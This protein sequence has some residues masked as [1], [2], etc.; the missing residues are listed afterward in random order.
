MSLILKYF[1]VVTY[2]FGL[3]LFEPQSVYASTSITV[4]TPADQ[5]KISILGGCQF[6]SSLWHCFQ[7]SA[8]ARAQSKLFSIKFLITSSQIITSHV[9]ALIRVL[10]GF[11]IFFVLKA[12]RAA[13]V[14]WLRVL[15]LLNIG[16]LTA[17]VRASLGVHVR[18][19]VLHRWVKWFFSGYSG[20]RPPLINVGS[21]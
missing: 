17:V 10:S 19:Q 9:M 5:S 18:C 6:S 20:F 7:E 16:S 21:I 13:V 12:L 1:K 8:E 3:T 14:Q 15:T 11:A 4:S 2:T